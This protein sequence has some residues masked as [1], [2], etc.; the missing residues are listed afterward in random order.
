VSELM[1]GLNESQRSAVQWQDGPLLVL[2]GPGSGKTRVLTSRVARLIHDAPGKRFRVLG[3]TFTNKAALEMRKRIDMLLRIDRERAHLTTFHSFAAD[4]LRQHGSHV[5]LRP[6]FA[7]VNEQADREALLADAIRQ[8]G[9]QFDQEVESSPTK[10]LPTL[11]RALDDCVRPAEVLVWLKGRVQADYLAVV[12]AAYWERL[13]ASNQLDF[14][15]LLAL[16]VH[17]LEDNAAIAKQVR[18]VYSYVCVDEFQDTNAAQFRLLVQLVNTR[19][20]N[21][22]VVADDDQI[23]YEWNGANPARLSEIRQRFDMHVIQLPENF[24]CPS[25][26]IALANKLIENNDDHDHSKEPLTAHKRPQDKC[27]VKL[28]EFSTAED[29]AAWLAQVLREMPAADRAASVI[30]ARRKRMLEFFITKLSEEQV[31]AYLAMR[32]SEFESAPFRWLHSLLRLANARADREQLRR[33]CRAFYHL[34]GIN[35]DPADVIAAAAMAENDLLR[36]WTETASRREGVSLAARAMLQELR[37]LLVDRLLY[38]EFVAGAKIWLSGV[39]TAVGNVP[40]STAFEEYETESE[41]WNALE[42]E[43]ATQAGESDLSL[44]NFLQELDLRAKER[45]APPN[46]V[47]CLTIHA[48]K[49]MEFKHVFLTGVVED[50]LPSWA[51][52]RK[53]D[54]SSEMREERRSCF[55]AI[56]RAEETL[57]LT[58]ARRYFGYDKAPSR[59]LR[60]MSL[61]PDA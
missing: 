59:F 5:G 44:H 57:T 28:Q 60:E 23:I 31:P 53:G 10:L 35:L 61:L 47:R 30:L 27:A 9:D 50:E 1:V 32:K 29:E 2:A 45:P 52:K 3:I 14:G 8:L 13:I 15:S 54:S 55:V 4:I 11:T 19:S 33:V 48:S 42:H 25:D 6:D 7:I 40:D 41:I 34:E 56:T 21:L 36:T 26:V 24:R 22:F 12:Y 39:A 18:R 20:P 51:A 17:L 16:A 49:G 46:A 43:I 58:Y 38:R 37:D